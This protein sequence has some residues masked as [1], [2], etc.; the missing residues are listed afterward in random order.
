MKKFNYRRYVVALVITAM[1]FT[2]G[3]LASS[4][5]TS[6]K[7][8]NVRNIEDNISLSI[9][10]SETE[11]DIIREVSCDDDN[12][13]NQTTLNK[14]I[15]D[16]A[17]KLEI[18]ESTNQNDDR[19]IAAKKRYSLLLIKDYLLTKKAAENCGKKPNTILY[20]YENA[21]SCPECVKTGAAL[22]SLKKDYERLRVY[23]IDYSLDLPVIKTLGNIYGITP[24]K[25]PAIVID[26]KVYV[27]LG[28]K[29]DIDIIIPKDV[30]TSSTTTA[31][32]TK[33]TN[34]VNDV[35]DILDRTK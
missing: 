20:F 1:I 27:G 8:D 10:A 33:K 18:L 21:D 5:L 9:L 16:L 23:S 22:T 17:E 26:K 24:E 35:K 7:L 6:R 11:N 29:E 2:T 32:T 12:S 30:K 19:I 34:I 13:K 3:F 4:M 14:E 25:L 31:T 28:K 15:N